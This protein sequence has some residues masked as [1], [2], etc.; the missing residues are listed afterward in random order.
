[1]LFDI[2][3]GMVATSQ[4]EEGTVKAIPKE[5]QISYEEALAFVQKKEEAGR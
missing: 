2:W 1:M 4:L 5:E 3:V